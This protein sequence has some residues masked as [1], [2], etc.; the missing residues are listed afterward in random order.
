M[1]AT[2]TVPRAMAAVAKRIVFIGDDTVPTN[3]P[4]RTAQR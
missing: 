3:R 4:L 1:I 2:L